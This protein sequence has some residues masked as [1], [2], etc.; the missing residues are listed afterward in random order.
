MPEGPCW[1]AK[2]S[3]GRSWA[4]PRDTLAHTHRKQAGCTQQ[5]GVEVPVGEPS[6]AP[7][8]R[9]PLLSCSVPLATLCHPEIHPVVSLLWDFFHP[10]IK[11]PPISKGC[12]IL[13][14]E[15][16]SS[17][18]MGRA[19]F[20]CQS[21]MH[22]AQAEKAPAGGFALSPGHLCLKGLQVSEQIS[23]CRRPWQDA[24][25]QSR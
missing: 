17:L 9:W 4:R 14:S 7:P 11:V 16:A 13:H 19:C 21:A 8:L 18:Q 1:F 6:S 2:R 10:F 22:T 23:V 24:A 15:S 12:P 25:A 3:R 5:L 20:A